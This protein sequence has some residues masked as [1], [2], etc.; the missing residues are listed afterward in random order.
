MKQGFVLCAAVALVLGTMA[1]AMSQE[2][3]AGEIKK[4]DDVK[5]TA[6][7]K[8]TGR[9]VEGV[10]K[11]V[12]PDG[13]VV[14]GREQNK[15]RDWAFAITDKTTVKRGEK[16]AFADDL[17]PGDAVTVNYVEQDGKIVAQS[18]ILSAPAKARPT[19]DRTGATKK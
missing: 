18:V 5:S 2:K 13:F 9:R 3:K 16:T 12:Q 7:G 1:P 15:E 11:S 17:K 4:S 14:S 6:S 19:T 10:V 8:A